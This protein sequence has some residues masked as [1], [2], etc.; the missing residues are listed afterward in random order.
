MRVIF[1]NDVAGV[2]RKF[3]VKDVADGYARNFLLPQ[4]L[5]VL[6]TAEAEARV[7]RER[8]AHETRRAVEARLLAQNI[9]ALEGA[10]V[11][12]AARANVRGQLFAGLDADEI[13]AAIEK[14]LRLAIPHE[15]IE[16]EK[17]IKKTG[18]HALTAKSGDA[19][20]NFTLIVKP[21]E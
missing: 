10:R 13:A 5:A 12:I 4:K 14:E 20:A 16:L 6:A 17:P 3:D 7:A 18:E 2:G 15:S 21:L 1:L 8:S 19:V 9:R 11:T